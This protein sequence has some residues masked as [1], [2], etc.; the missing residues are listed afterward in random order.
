[1]WVEGIYK[2]IE[3]EAYEN[4][5]AWIENGVPNTPVNLPRQEMRPVI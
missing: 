2:T 3:E 5:H 1:M 4:I